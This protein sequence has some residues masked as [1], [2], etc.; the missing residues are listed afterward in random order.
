[1]ATLIKYRYGTFDH[2]ILLLGRLADFA[3]KDLKRKRL[4][5]KVNGGRW[6][7]PESMRMQSQASQASHGLPTTPPQQQTQMPGFSGMVPGVQEPKLPMGFE[8]SRDTSPQSTRS[9]DID[10]QAQTQE[11]EEEWQDIRNA[12]SVLEDHFGADFQALGPEFSAPIQTPFGTALQYRTVSL[13][14]K[15]NFCF[16]AGNREFEEP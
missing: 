1:M 5:M 15:S 7:P 3:A 8:A 2:L 9:D 16:L 10:L 12:F 6:Q 13:I 4:A 11:A 14:S